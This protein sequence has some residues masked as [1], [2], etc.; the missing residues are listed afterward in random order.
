LFLEPVLRGRGVSCAQRFVWGVAQDRLKQ[1]PQSAFCA[2][3][4]RIAKTKHKILRLQANVEGS[5]REGGRQAP[6]PK[7]ESRNQAS[8]AVR[9]WGAAFVRGASCINDG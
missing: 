3:V 6:L 9:V 1:A 5:L 7:K 8:L 4:W 2:L